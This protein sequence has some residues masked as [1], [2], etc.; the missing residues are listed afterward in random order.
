[1]FWSRGKSRKVRTMGAILLLLPLGN[2]K[3]I[4]MCGRFEQSRQLSLGK[5]VGILT[6]SDS[7]GS[8]SNEDSKWLYNPI[9]V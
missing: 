7:N 6:A 8:P 4:A 1:M 3:K 5:L 9:R 2:G